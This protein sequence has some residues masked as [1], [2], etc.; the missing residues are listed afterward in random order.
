MF[1][2]KL[3]PS[4]FFLATQRPKLY[5]LWNSND[6][7]LISVKIIQECN[8]G[9]INWVKIFT[10]NEVWTGTYNFLDPIFLPDKKQT[11][12]ENLPSPNKKQIVSLIII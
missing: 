10:S 3:G 2:S 6:T 12:C 11:Y 4:S 9:I 8:G 7:A 1:D 5:K